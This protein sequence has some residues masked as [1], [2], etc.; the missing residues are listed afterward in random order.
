MTT[1]TDDAIRY[2][3][4]S[5]RSVDQAQEAVTAAA[6]KRKFGLLHH[7]DLKQ[8]LKGKGFDLEPEVRVLEIC[9]PGFADQVLKA[10]VAMNM[11]LPCRISVWQEGGATHIGM[12]RPK[13]MLE[14]LTEAPALRRLADEV[15][16][17][18]VEMI[19]EAR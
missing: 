14:M 3:V 17:L 15:E 19:D 2:V 8:T 1:V 13:A 6:Q 12:I 18:M 9:N 11:G 5:A 16:R 4:Q 7:Y 10:E